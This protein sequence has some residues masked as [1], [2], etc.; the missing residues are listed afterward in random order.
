[1]KTP[2]EDFIQTIENALKIT[3]DDQTKAI[4][5]EKEKQQIIEAYK[6]G[7]QQGAQYIAT[8]PNMERT[9]VTSEQYYNETY[10]K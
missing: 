6:V 1:M 8:P 7:V 10:N 2:V 4:Y 3:I 9:L 5:L